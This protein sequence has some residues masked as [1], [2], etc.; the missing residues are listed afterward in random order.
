M[1]EHEDEKY[2][3]KEYGR[4]EK[5]GMRRLCGMRPGMEIGNES[6]D[7]LCVHHKGYLAMKET[8]LQ[9]GIYAVL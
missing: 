8:N 2:Q 1:D 5:M 7:N 6:W 9:N 3:T 4:N